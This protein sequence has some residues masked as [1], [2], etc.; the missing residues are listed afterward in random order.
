MLAIRLCKI[1]LVAASALFLAL[2][3][4]NNLT[5]Y[6]SNFL[7]VEG[8]LSMSTAFDDN[9]LMWRAIDS[10]LIHTLFYGSIILWESLALVLCIWGTVTLGR[11]VKEKSGAIF[12]KAKKI[13]TIGLTVSLLQWYVAFITV[14]GEWFLMWQSDE[15]NGQDAAFRMFS[16]MGISL[17][18]LSLKDDDLE[19]ACN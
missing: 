10:S 8:V 2:V 13:A 14:G 6:S 12:N 16:I 3:V 5:D 15:W 17:I 11:S 19:D 7:F 4:L 18:F 9:Q 1:S